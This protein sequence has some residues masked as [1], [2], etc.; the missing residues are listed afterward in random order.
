MNVGF[1]VEGETERIIVESKNFSSYL[2][3][4]GL[5]LV[6]PVVDA[7]GNGNLLPRYL[8]QHVIQICAANSN[9]VDHIFVLTDLED[10]PG[11]LHIKNRINHKK[12]H[13]DLVLI[14]VKAIESWLIADSK[15]LSKALGDSDE[16]L[17]LK[18]EDTVEKPWEFLKKFCHSN[19][20]RGPGPLKT[21]FAKKMIRSGFD[22]DNI[23]T[24]PNLKSVKYLKK[25]LENIN[26]YPALLP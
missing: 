8:E 13:P 12:I 15:S 6:S 22:I 19:K 25:V 11:F 20:I 10:E 17:F 26:N 2:N 24:H 18:P 9:N 3:K 5:N 1:I 23:V 14:S 16:F 4:Y 21:G 7:K